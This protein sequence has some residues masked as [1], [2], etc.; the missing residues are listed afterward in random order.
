MKRYGLIGMLLILA[1]PA[2]AQQ[3]EAPTEL[4]LNV[5][6]E[7]HYVL[8]GGGYVQ[9]QIKLRLLLV[10][11]HPFETLNLDFPTIEG[12]RVLTLLP[13]RTRQVRFYDGLGYAYESRFA[14][15]P[16]R[17]GSL[18]IPPIAVSGEVAPSPGQRE[19]FQ[20]QQPA[21]VIDVR[22]I[23]PALRND[24]WLVSEAVAFEESWT[25]DPED[26]RVGDTVQ[27]HVTLI[28]KGVTVEQLP[29]IE[30]SQDQGYAVVGVRTKSNTEFTKDGVVS[31]IRQTW[32]LRIQSGE[33]FHIGPI[34]VDYWDPVTDRAATAGLPSK[35][36][37]PLVQYA[38]ATRKALIDDA[39]TAHQNRRLGAVVLLAVPGVA[40]GVA[41]ILVF[42]AALPTRADR[43][44]IRRCNADATAEAS[45]AAVLIWSRESYG[46]RGSLAFARLRA[47]LGIAGAGPLVDL[48]D[49]LFA[50]RLRP[51]NPPRVA[52]ALVS[53]S[54]RQRLTALWSRL[55]SPLEG[56]FASPRL[57]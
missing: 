36:V 57:D 19:A 54:R 49:S 17:S 50:P 51:L 42:F 8:A 27:R 43:R 3:V 7:P 39:V 2:T 41:L 30:Q 1:G 11:P 37:E 15:F 46:W 23:N 10:S 47:R 21:T 52:R 34:Q 45:L 12:A 32:D 28:A 40:A 35:R 33:V 22:P 29:I 5:I 18:V 4:E 24:W 55:W 13:A 6:V 48:Q 14:L 25:P 9:G 53:S 20:L 56:Y 44:L 31:W 16:E 26:F 38:D